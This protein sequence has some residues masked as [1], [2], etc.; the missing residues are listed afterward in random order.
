MALTY[1]SLKIALVVLTAYLFSL[2]TTIT[3]A[4]QAARVYPAEALRYE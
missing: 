3:P 4:W 2:I 1:A